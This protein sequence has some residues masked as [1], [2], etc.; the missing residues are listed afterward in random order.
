MED[1]LAAV[2]EPG[3]PSV[4]D[5]SLDAR[6]SAEVEPPASEFSLSCG[7]RVPDDSGPSGSM[8]MDEH[9]QYDAQTQFN[10]DEEESVTPRES[11]IASSVESGS[12]SSGAKRGLSD[13]GDEANSSQSILVDVQDAQH[14][15]KKIKRLFNRKGPSGGVTKPVA[16]PGR[17]PMPAVVASRPLSR[18]KST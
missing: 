7:Q 5:S 16:K 14:L 10:G 15:V 2:S 18:S 1:S 6:P 3:A 8:P 13:P 9:S 11:V 12:V 17:H 4:S